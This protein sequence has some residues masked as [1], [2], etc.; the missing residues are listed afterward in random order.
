MPR[1]VGQ[2]L[3]LKVFQEKLEVALSVMVELTRGDEPKG[4]LNDLRGFVQH[5]WFCDSVM[6]S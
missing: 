5:K 1:E 2:S 3:S 6:I 4:G